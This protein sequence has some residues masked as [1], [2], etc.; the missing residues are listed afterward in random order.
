MPGQST[1]DVAIIGGGAS[2]LA[3][4]VSA[5]RAGQ[6]VAVIERDVEMGLP[7][8]ATGNGRC[9]L[10]NID[11]DPVRYRHPNIARKVMGE[12]PEAELAAFFESLGLMTCEVDGRLYPYSKRADSVREALL[13]AALRPGTKALTCTEVERAAY[14]ESKGIWNLEVSRPAKPLPLPK[15]PLEFKALIRAQRKELRRA[16][17]ARETLFARRVI[18]ACGGSSK[19][20]AELFGLPHIPEEPVLCPVACLPAQGGRPEGLRD[21][22]LRWLDGL[23]VDCRLSLVRNGASIWTEDGEVLFRAYGLSGIVAFDLSRRCI[24]GDIVEIDLFP[25]YSEHELVALFA[26]RAESFGDPENMAAAWFT[27]LFDGSGKESVSSGWEEGIQVSLSDVPVNQLSS[28]PQ[29]DLSYLALMEDQRTTWTKE[30]VEDYYGLHFD[31]MEVP[32]GMQAQTDLSQGMPVWINDDGSIRFDGLKLY[33][34]QDASQQEYPEGTEKSLSLTASKIGLLNLSDSLYRTDTVKTWRFQ[35]TEITIGYCAMS[36]GPYDET[37]HAPAGTYYPVY[38]AEFEY[39]GA[40]YRLVG[41]R[42]SRRDM[43]TAVATLLSQ[44]EDV[45]IIS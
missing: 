10:S 7:I 37:T 18:I 31:T 4:A 36:C 8:L 1:Y 16:E 32:A 34:T 30:Q 20:L 44:G 12:Q 3:A 13:M 24:P 42:I 28:L 17:R 14:D 39:G 41:Q 5:A 29:S 21:S 23:R 19:H 25:N 2:G 40:Q 45:E 9:N 26:R 27:G 11:L 15:K 33:F 22:V 35:G 6:R 38:T 43:V